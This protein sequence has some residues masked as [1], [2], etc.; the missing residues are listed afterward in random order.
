MWTNSAPPVQV[1]ARTT[2]LHVTDVVPPSGEVAVARLDGAAM[3]DVDG[4]FEQFAD[5]LRFPSYFGWN[6]PALA[7]CLQDLH[8]LAARRFLVLIENTSRILR[9]NETRRE[10]LFGILTAAGRHWADSYDAR[11]RGMGPF[12][13]VVLLCE[14]DEVGSLRQEV[15]AASRR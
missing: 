13:H 7:D 10:V 8:W 11:Y 15:E 14:E 12:F 2:L 6:W 1:L 5:A 3:T 9:E 4:V